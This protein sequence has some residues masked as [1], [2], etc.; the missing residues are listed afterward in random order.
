MASTRR[1]VF[2]RAVPDDV[3]IST[4][5]S[6]LHEP[7]NFIDLSPYVIDYHPLPPTDNSIVTSSRI[8]SLR[9]RV[10]YLPFGF[11]AGSVTVPITYTNQEDGMK[12]IKQPPVGVTVQEHWF[13][14]PSETGDRDQSNA[15]EL[16]LNAE[17][18][19][20]PLVL[21]LFEGMMKR[22]F[23]SYI[24]GMVKVFSRKGTSGS[25]SS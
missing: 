25:D 15:T 16:V 17:I 11:W 2:S 22:A 14:R 1:F 5:I 23:E 9:D 3:S 6:C 12:I 13:V 19:G 7:P 21:Y 8:Y 4:A 20:N 10:D 18:D 24:D